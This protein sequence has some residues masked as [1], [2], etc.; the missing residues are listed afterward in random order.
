MSTCGTGRRRSCSQ[1]LSEKCHTDSFQRAI[2]GD[3]L[4]KTFHLSCANP[5][6]Y[7]RATSAPTTHCCCSMVFPSCG[8]DVTSPS[9]RR[10]SQHLTCGFFLPSLDS[11]LCCTVCMTTFTALSVCPAHVTDSFLMIHD[12]T[13]AAHFAVQIRTSSSS[14]LMSCFRAHYLQYTSFWLV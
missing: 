10:T 8:Y 13:C 9:F 2:D 3:V 1:I 7:L 11:L 12:L 14:S 5:V 4:T 6:G